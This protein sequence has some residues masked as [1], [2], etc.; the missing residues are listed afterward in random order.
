MKPG[1]HL[2]LLLFVAGVF[3]SPAGGQNNCASADPLIPGQVHCG[4][5]ADSGD[6]VDNNDCLGAWD[7]GNDFFF[8]FTPA[9]AEDGWLLSLFLSS[10]H[11]QAGIAL[12]QNCPEGN[13]EICLAAEAGAAQI[14]LLSPPLEAGQIYWI[15]ISSNQS[16]PS[17]TFCLESTL[18]P[19]GCTNPLASNYDPLAIV[20]DGSCS[21]PDPFSDCSMSVSQPDQSIPDGAFLLDTIS[22]T[23][24]ANSVVQ[25]I[26]LALW[27]E[28]PYMPDL[29]LSLISPSG[30]EVLLIQDQ[31]PAADSLYLRLDD[32]SGPWDC[33]SL[34][35]SFFAPPNGTLSAFS[36]EL[37][38][39]DWILKVED[40]ALGDTGWLNAWC[41]IPSLEE[42]D[43]LSPTGLLV[44]EVTA[45]AALISWNEP[46]QPPATI[47]DVELV[48]LGET[49]TGSP[50][51]TNISEVPYLLEGLQPAQ[52]YE[53]YLRSRCGPVPGSW[54]APRQF[55]T[56]I[57][58]PSTCGLNIPVSDCGIPALTQF[59]LNVSSAPGQQLGQDVFL[60]EVRLIV[61]HEYA[62]DLEVYLT[63]PNGVEV[64]LTT[65]NGGGDPNYGIP[66]FF[67]CQG[68]T[69]FS[70]EACRSIDDD[71]NNAPFLGA[72]LPEGDLTDFYDGSSPIG[73][74]T[75]SICDDAGDDSGNLQYVE[76]VFDS[77]LCSAP[78]VVN[79]DSTGA[80]SVFL[81]WP[82]NGDCEQYI[83]E[84][85]P[86]GFVPG[87]GL[88]PGSPQSQVVLIP[89]GAAFPIFL[90]TLQEST[91]YELVIR[92][93]CSSGVYSVNGCPVNF[94]TDCD[95]GPQTSLETFDTESLCSTTCGEPCPL[96]SSQWYN[97][98]VD[99]FDWIIDEFKTP[100]SRTGPNSDVSGDGRFLYIETSK[101]LCPD[102]GKASLLS[103]CMEVDADQ[104]N[105]HFSFYY[106]MYGDDI[107]R[108]QVLAS[109]SN[110]MVWDTLWSLEGEQGQQWY[111]SYVDLSAY[112]GDTIQL[113]I[114]GYKGFGVRGDI[115]IDQLAF[116]GSTSLG[117]P[118]NPFFADKDNDS[119]GDPE[120]AIFICGT[121]PPPAYV[122]NS[123]DCDD[124][125][126]EINPMASEIPCNQIDEN[127]NGN[128]DDPEL[129]LPEV[130]STT[131][132]AGELAELSATGPSVGQYYWKFD[133]PSAPVV[134]SGGTFAFL[135]D[136][137]RTVFVRDSIL[138]N[139]YLCL[140]DWQEASVTAL[141]QPVLSVPAQLIACP[142]ESVDLEESG[143]TDVSGSGATL[144]F[145]KLFPG[146]D[147]LMPAV[148]SP[149]ENQTIY[150]DAVSPGGCID[151]DSFSL[152]V[153]DPPEVNILPVGPLTLCSGKP[154]ELEVQWQSSS[155]SVSISWSNGFQDSSVLVYGNP[156][157]GSLDY[158]W[159]EVSDE[160]GCTGR[161][162]IEV[163]T[164]ESISAASVDEVID[165]SSCNGTNGGIII[166][167]LNGIPPYDYTW[168]GPISGSAAGVDSTLVINNLSQGA[169]RLTI[170]DGSASGCSL[171][172][173][174]I[175]VNGP[176]AVVSDV[177][178]IDVSCAGEA[179]GSIFLQIM[180]G[181][182]EISWST[183]DSTA[184]IN[185]LEGGL[186]S[187]TIQDGNCSLILEDLFVEEPE[188]LSLF[189]AQI[190]NVSCSYAADGRIQVVAQGGKGGYLYEWDNGI[191]N[192]MI[193]GLI[194]GNYQLTVTDF[195][196]CSLL[197]TFAV[198]KPD[199]L[200][201]SLDSVQHISCAGGD[202]GG[203]FVTPQGG[204][205][206]WTFDWSSGSV[207]EDNTEVSAGIY[208]LEI[209]DVNGCVYQGAS[210]LV[211]EPPVL[212]LELLSIQNASCNTAD[213]GAI[214]LT[215]SGG[216]PPYLISWSDGQSGTQLTGLSPGSYS[217]TVSDINGCVKT[218]DSLQISAPELLNLQVSQLVNP[219][220]LG[221]KDGSIS[222]N[223]SGGEAPYSFNW[224]NGGE[225]PTINA[226]DT[227]AYFCT[228]SDANGCF[229]VLDTLVL[230]TS[231]V[232]NGAIDFV[233]DLTCFQSNDGQIFITLTGGTQPYQYA[234]NDSISLADRQALPPGKYNCT[235]T[236]SKGCQIVLPTVEID[237]P[238]LLWIGLN[239]VE[240]VL[241]NGLS[242]GSIDIFVEGGVPPY[243]YSWD[244][245]SQL[246]DLQEAPAGIYKLTIL[247]QNGCLANLDSLVL[248]QPEPIS[249]FTEPQ[250]SE[251]CEASNGG[252]ADITVSGGISPYLFEWSNGSTEEDLIDVPA[253]T[254]ALTITDANQCKSI[255]PAIPVLATVDSLEV[256][257]DTLIPISCFNTDDGQ[258]AVSILGGTLP[259]QYLWN[260]G[261]DSTLSLSELDPGDYQLT[262]TDGRGCTYVSPKIQMLS[263]A[264]LSV[265]IDS[266]Q[267]PLCP[268]AADG[269]L[270]S[271][272]TGGVA[273]YQYVWYN[274]FGDTV[275]FVE[276]PL[277][278]PSGLYLAQLT[279]ENGCSAVSATVLLPAPENLTISVLDTVP[280]CTG[281]STG[282]I[283]INLEGGE[284]PYIYQWSN[285][286]ISEDLLAAPPGIYQ[287]TVID[288]NE[289]VY[290]SDF[291][292]VDALSDL[293][294]SATLDSLKEVDCFAEKTGF[295]K[296]S[297][298]GGTPPYSYSWSNGSPF[299]TINNVLA[300]TYFCT[301]SDVNA[302]TY[303]IPPVIIQQ[304]DTALHYETD[305]L[306][307]VSCPA[308]NDGGIFI[309][310]DG[311]TQ[312]YAFLWNNNAQTEDNLGL[313]SGPY[314]FTLTDHQGCTHVSETFGISQPSP[315]EVEV[316]VEPSTNGEANGSAEL[317][318]SGGTGPYSYLWD[319]L[320]GGQT[321]PFAD[322]L[323][324]G[325]YYTT[326]TDFN[327]CD[328][329]VEVIIEN[330]TA[331]GEINIGNGNEVL[332]FPNPTRGQVSVYWE[333]IPLSGSPELVFYNAVG[334]K[335]GAFT[336]SGKENT[337]DLS[338]WPSGTY[339][340]RIPGFA[341][342]GKI[343]LIKE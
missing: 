110:E 63:S 207:L 33:S 173:P 41:L 98:E 15:H 11:D 150:V 81:S 64:E 216:E 306:L 141:P 40:D 106:N 234:W 321:T 161:D 280:S 27:L 170:T 260:T 341:F 199:S 147:P 99:D 279:D 278:L 168:S 277:E 266:I 92:K 32:A 89:C 221:R 273:P 317:D 213:D 189:S 165:V 91:I 1:K 22:L 224:N 180:G 233:N 57:A 109:R 21:F 175:V 100:S 5:T 137:S 20:D 72:F 108:L 235:V 335:V 282:Q 55:T 80:G 49:P 179:D 245:G 314:Q 107:Y 244:N 101:N 120:D 254:Y 121:S 201:F 297:G 78:D 133:D 214:E 326:V 177:Q 154:A 38:A 186:Y 336:L 136:T 2:L 206:P 54:S 329:I 77:L 202:D 256:M 167:P 263:P 14:S 29:K 34:T 324:E 52:T 3:V 88:E 28:H 68:V 74:W 8:S 209:S 13:N 42:V 169:Y 162:S 211:D 178:I 90:Q 94:I 187:V 303:T 124:S 142:G 119:F 338:N 267:E 76:L 66:G 301:I 276:D 159:V 176:S 93:E 275:S 75:L 144:S 18:G 219:S 155:D 123:L 36:A 261:I 23:V 151:I 325:S 10:E 230:S 302:C 160:G 270:F 287:L 83:L 102:G 274:S 164:T 308:G 130:N 298:L 184:S 158:Y 330:I 112:N 334:Q 157:P 53:L 337:L 239:S 204:T 272:P 243:Q 332:L 46:N 195:N 284:A 126:A 237:E 153:F 129:P 255:R 269:Q 31:C 6:G 307:D 59:P 181:N 318:V 4:N 327:A 286:A 310:A 294:L 217:V 232:L 319:P 60:K 149:S 295:A 65:D 251:D 17:L 7:E 44:E 290:T 205:P 252:S 85:G 171:V 281:D 51:L 328:T 296:V 320:A 238:P 215:V 73:N 315:L 208:Q 285:G 185:G 229:S 118:A 16:E 45:T 192:S 240:P 323:S 182:P 127:C 103:S 311:G 289:C 242:N 253:G 146:G 97:A 156:V 114:D 69:V 70:Q 249:V 259:Y 191:F 343:I 125:D 148:L 222:L 139:G 265:L 210:V 342:F 132:C 79:V 313:L 309:S 122:S 145:Y 138:E 116:Y 86:P 48:P 111:K 248:P 50:T 26:D 35:S 58:N 212:T 30:T 226:L 174:L 134:G 246:E 84:Y 193:Q 188:P 152:L 218:L 143:G 264:P 194:P 56:A 104:G 87:N 24:S 231:Q 140:S 333:N 96:S 220:C 293:A 262:V 291:I 227:G 25:D 339:L 299:A 117:F 258:I 271:T 292:P 67:D 312:P 228:V 316:F 305:S 135:A 236:D 95:S 304:P 19:E 61:E 268:A 37:A 166:S 47:W 225:S 288:A 71:A 200:F 223:V 241:C 183:G 196:G 340:Y 203:I 300:G 39:G 250:E 105:C 172:I 257:L 322:G 163:F 198:G 82:S 128:Y 9:A 331:V 197:D 113:R 43:C 283:S 62:A 190:A 12:L 131:V 115:A 247:D